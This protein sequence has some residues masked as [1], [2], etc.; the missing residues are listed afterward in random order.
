MTDEEL[1]SLYISPTEPLL[2]FF[3]CSLGPE[4]LTVLCESSLDGSRVS[5]NYMCSYDD[6]QPE[7]CEQCSFSVIS[8]CACLV[9]QNA[10]LSLPLPSPGGPGPEIVIDVERYRPGRRV[11]LNITA[12]TGGGQSIEFLIDFITSGLHDY[13]TGCMHTLI[14]VYINCSELKPTLRCFQSTD[15][16]LIL[17]SCQGVP[18][19]VS[20]LAQCSYNHKD[21]SISSCTSL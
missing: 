10:Y 15:G 4:G 21:D 8:V 3:N 18:F 1:Y 2:S 13:G 11:R 5:I 14:I 9:P 6:S 12:T 16:P 17:L 7:D 20:G 19:S